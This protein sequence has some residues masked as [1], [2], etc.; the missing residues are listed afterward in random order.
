M[1]PLGQG[2]GSEGQSD[3]LR[4]ELQG[5]ALI[6]DEKLRI[7]TPNPVPPQLG[8]MKLELPEA[9]HEV[10]SSHPDTILLLSQPEPSTQPTSAFLRIITAHK[11]GAMVTTQQ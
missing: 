7:L 9:H 5:H 4:A 6:W 2:L 10:N 11:T 3:T 1:S 8:N